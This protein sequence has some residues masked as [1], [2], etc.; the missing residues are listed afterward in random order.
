MATNDTVLLPL[1]ERI[2]T[3]EKHLNGNKQSKSQV[4]RENM[5]WLGL[6]PFQPTKSFYIYYI[7]HLTS[8]NNIM[9]LIHQAEQ[10]TTFS[11]HTQG[12]YRQAKNVLIKI[13]FIQLEQLQSIVLIFQMLHLSPN[14]VKSF[15]M[16][17]LLLKTIFHP[18]K[19][20]YTWTYNKKDLYTLVRN[21]YLTRTMLKDLNIIPLQEPFKQW[22]NRTFKHHTNCRVPFE[23]QTDDSCCTCS[24]RPYK[25]STAKWTINKAVNSIF[26]E[27]ICHSNRNAMTH[28]YE[29]IDAI[30]YCL[31]ITKLTMVIELDWTMEQLN[32]YNKLHQGRFTSLYNI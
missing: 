12:Q 26:N 7:H 1:P 29:F 27:F 21:Q 3:F 23:Y 6:H 2:D 16:I 18:W 14:N 5:N 20:I 24:Y 22:Y 10:T 8:I 19:K 25:N 15:A 30:H 9:F 11:I 17:Q 31:A 4:Q 28:E 32:Q 13:E